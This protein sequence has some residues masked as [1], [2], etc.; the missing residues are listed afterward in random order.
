[1]STHEKKTQADEDEQPNTKSR[2]VSS[3]PLTEDSG[4][5]RPNSRHVSSEPAN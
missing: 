2:H 3:E 1:M 5:I 4:E